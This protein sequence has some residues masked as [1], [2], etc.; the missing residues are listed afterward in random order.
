MR[1]NVRNQDD[2]VSQI[3][4]PD[5]T[6]IQSLPNLRFF[7]KSDQEVLLQDLE[8]YAPL[9]SARAQALRAWTHSY[10]FAINSCLRKEKM[11]ELTRTLTD[12]IVNTVK[13]MLPLENLVLF[14]GVKPNDVINRQSVIGDR[15][16]DSGFSTKSVYPNVGRRFIEKKYDCNPCDVCCL[17][18]IYYPDLSQHVYL[19]ADYTDFK[20]ESEMLTFPGETFEIKG[21]GSMTVT[22]GNRQDKVKVF[23]CEYVGS[24]EDNY[25]Y[26]N[27]PVYPSVDETFD[28]N[29]E[30]ME[31]VT[32]VLPVD[33][34]PKRFN[35]GVL[36]STISFN[37]KLNA[38]LKRPYDRRSNRR[39]LRSSW[40]S[41]TYSQ[42]L[43]FDFSWLFESP[44]D[45]VITVTFKRQDQ[46]STYSEDRDNEFKIITDT[47]LIFLRYQLISI[48]IKVKNV[49]IPVDFKVYDIALPI[50][51]N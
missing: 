19:S 51:V 47:V 26:Q 11:T 3:I 5:S 30:L 49:N 18:M 32:F 2:K 9:G 28:R 42:F 29:L 36:Y 17:L 39:R 50:S 1:F 46:T 25:K 6:Y 15:I 14:R 13:L 27:Y 38:L 22:T 23:L 12:D 40:H 31:T 7:S 21:V 4:F 48:D 20:E 16:T 24:V 41:L 33:I 8:N 10:D 44:L 37:S 45:S 34:D 35:E 43:L